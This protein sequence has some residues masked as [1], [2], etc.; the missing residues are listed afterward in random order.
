[1]LRA[2]LITLVSIVMSAANNDPIF[3]YGQSNRKNPYGTKS[4]PLYDPAD[5]EA[6]DAAEAAGNT[7]PP[8]NKTYFEVAQF[9]GKKE[10]SHQYA[11]DTLKQ[12]RA[13]AEAGRWTES[14]K[15]SNMLDN[16]LLDEGKDHWEQA[17]MWGNGEDDPID[18]DDPDDGDFEQVVTNMFG[19]MA[20]QDYPANVMFDYFSG[21]NY[22][23]DILRLFAHDPVQYLYKLRKL[24]TL[25]GAELAMRDGTEPT[26]DMRRDTFWRSFSADARHWVDQVDAG[27]ANEYADMTRQEISKRM[28]AF[29]GPKVKEAMLRLRNKSNHD[30]GSGKGNG[31][32]KRFGK[33]KRGRGDGHDDNGTKKRKYTGNK[34]PCPFHDGHNFGQCAA[35]PFQDNR[36]FDKWQCR[37][38]LGREDIERDFPWFVKACE[39]HRGLTL[40]DGVRFD[41]GKPVTREGRPI[42]RDRRPGRDRRDRRQQGNGVQNNNNSTQQQQQQQQQQH[43]QFQ[44]APPQGLPPMP[45]GSVILPPQGPPQVQNQGTSYAFGNNSYQQTAAV[46]SA[47]VQQASGGGRWVPAPGGGYRLV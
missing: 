46:G 35:R 47:P 41:G 27:G 26:E 31:K 28:R 33:R 30:D 8:V 19:Q 18:A 39:K 10:F 4:F 11:R 32:N 21:I 25:T 40:A 24:E 34:D 29:Y 5:I 36:R 1:M 2:S 37:K 38:V 45:V 44:F 16:V 43:Q 22:D 3:V 9:D 13:T 42:S 12:F 23:E 7:R 17:I 15:F 20:G 14:K 6:A